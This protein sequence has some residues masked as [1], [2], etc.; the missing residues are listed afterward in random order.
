MI[1][2]EGI[3]QY[4]DELVP[5][6]GKGPVDL[7]HMNEHSR[8]MQRG[9]IKESILQVN[10][11]MAAADMIMA[12]N[13]LEVQREKSQHLQLAEDVRNMVEDLV[14][15]FRRFQTIEEVP[16]PDNAKF[17]KTLR[18]RLKFEANTAEKV[19]KVANKAVDWLNNISPETLGR[20]KSKTIIVGKAENVQTVFTGDVDKDLNSFRSK[21]ED[22][23]DG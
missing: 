6:E 12:D 7:D 10:A 5:L 13:T 19:L 21:Q 4:G 8:G 22:P 23:N 11:K 3:P 9:I 16:S 15:G 1:E 2:G 18:G 17:K 20:G 14:Q